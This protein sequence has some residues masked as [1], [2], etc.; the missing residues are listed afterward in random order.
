[1][2]SGINPSELV[3]CSGCGRCP[4]VLMWSAS[5]RLIATLPWN[6]NPGFPL[7]VSTV[8]CPLALSILVVVLFC[9][10]LPCRWLTLILMDDFFSV[11]F[12]SIRNLFVS[13]VCMA[14]IAT[15]LVISFWMTSP[16]GWI[17]RSPLFWL[18]ISALFLTVL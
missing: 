18:V 7:L 14:P 3:L 13:A 16:L 12:R 5:R 10:A 15:L 8:L 1:M 9:F 2:G 11:S 6:A 17:P 4:Y